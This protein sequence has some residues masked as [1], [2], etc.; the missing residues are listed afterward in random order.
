M[1]FFDELDSIDYWNK[2]SVILTPKRKSNMAQ[3]LKKQ[4]SK[5][6]SDKNVPAV[7]S[8]KS[9]TVKTPEATVLNFD[10]SKSFSRFLEASCD[11]C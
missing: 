7:S 10:T 5:P 6:I 2:I 4:I 11:C 9:D 3:A 1:N 8:Q